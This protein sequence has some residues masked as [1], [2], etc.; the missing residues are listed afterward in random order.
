MR[1][2]SDKP[3]LRDIW[4]I[5]SPV[6]LKIGKIIENK[7]YIRNYQSPEEAKETWWLNNVVSWLWSLFFKI[8]YKLVKSKYNVEFS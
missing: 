8:R 4:Q 2:I 3:K 1:K 5:T 6:I 7:K